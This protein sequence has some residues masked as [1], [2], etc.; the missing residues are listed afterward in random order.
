MT[1]L[2]SDGGVCRTAPAT[3]GLL[4]VLVPQYVLVAR[5]LNIGSVAYQYSVTNK[6]CPEAIVCTAVYSIQGKAHCTLSTENVHD[7]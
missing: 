1:D 5:Y 4:N 7:Y 2:M 6:L 3:P